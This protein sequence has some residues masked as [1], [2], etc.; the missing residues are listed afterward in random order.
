MLYLVQ[1][2]TF[3]EFSKNV[4]ATPAVLIFVS[5]SINFAVNKEKIESLYETLKALIEQGSLIH[6]S[7]GTKL[8]RRIKQTDKIFKILMSC[9]IASLAM[10]VLVVTA[11][12]KLPMKMW[13]P[14]DY[15]S[16]EALFWMSAVYQVSVGFI[17]TPIAVLID[18]F[19]LYLLSFMTGIIEE[20]CAS[21]ET[22][23]E[24]KKA[25][26]PQ[27]NNAMS[28]KTVERLERMENLEHLM[29]CVKIHQKVIEIAATF[30]EIF[31]KDFWLQGMISIVLLC[32]NSYS[33]TV[34]SESYSKHYYDT[35]I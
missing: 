28:L 20:L 8:M 15:T 30:N 4:V 9:A 7:S 2:Q 25:K 5:K 23:C 35:S 31:G 6:N 19:P 17:I 13:F 10:S 21:L 16:N 27:E 18:V 33:L 1:V 24:L 29:K 26:K 11:A 22:V 34:V 14:F 32:T 3:E 12:H